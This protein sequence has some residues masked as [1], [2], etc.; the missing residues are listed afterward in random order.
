MTD[1][2]PSWNDGGARR[3]IEEFVQ[4][5]G[6][7]PA[8][9]RVAVFDNDGTLWCEK[10]MPIQLDFILRR[11]VEMAEA[12]PELRERQPWK[13]ALR[14]RLRLARRAD[15]RALRRRRHQ[16]E[17]RWPAASWP[18]TPG[19]ASRTSRRSPTTFLRSAQHPTLGRGYLESRLRA[20]GRAA[21]LPGRERVRELH[22]LGR[23]PRLHAADQPGGLRHPARA[24]HRQRHDARLH[25]ATSAAARSPT[26]PRPTT[27]T[28]ARRS[29]SGSGAAPAAGRC[30]PPAT[31]TATSR[32]STS[33]STPTSRSLRLLVLHD[34]AR[35]RVRLHHRRRAGARESQQGRLDGRQHQERLGHRLLETLQ[36]G[37]SDAGGGTRTLTPRKGDTRF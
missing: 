22:R 7:V 2:L 15:G 5:S 32:C 37:V 29:R 28:T 17:G 20:D 12:K 23:R 3:A 16:R 36:E 21:R 14:A 8:E 1:P 10:P 33:P 30:S 13:A 18:P 9:E 35:A 27:S 25:A 26:R 24:G 4:D 31:R 6:A 11:L 19:S 34:D